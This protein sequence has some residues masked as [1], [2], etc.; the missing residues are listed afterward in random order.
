M[1]THYQYFRKMSF[2]YTSAVFYLS[3]C[4]DQLGKNWK[5]FWKPIWKDEAFIAY[6]IAKWKFSKLKLW[7]GKWIACVNLLTCFLLFVIQNYMFM[8]IIPI[9]G[10][11][12]KR[13]KDGDTYFHKSCNLNKLSVVIQILYCI[14]LNKWLLGYRILLHKTEF[15]ICERL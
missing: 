2:F 10:N 1:L 9:A 13:Y 7:F 15:V 4:L 12:D 8:A 3:S 14:H 11:W 6:M 5:I